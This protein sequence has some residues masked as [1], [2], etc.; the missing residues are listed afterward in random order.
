M[1]TRAT[2]ST[3]CNFFSPFQIGHSLHLCPFS[4]HLKHSTSTVSYLLIVVSL[5]SHCITLLDNTSNLFW[6]TIPLFSSPSLF[7]QFWTRCL[8]PLQY[9]YTLLL[10]SSNSALSLVRA[11]FWLSRL[12]MRALY[13]IW[14]I[15]LTSQGYGVNS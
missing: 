12:L 2:F 11:C 13:C 1:A 9:R 14:D 4:P 15:V 6:G 3:T 10:L 5:T 7:L 8:N